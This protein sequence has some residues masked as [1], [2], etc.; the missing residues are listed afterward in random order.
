MKGKK[1]DMRGQYADFQK[2][3]IY[4]KIKRGGSKKTFFSKK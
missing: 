3:Y 1:R 2:K 4:Y